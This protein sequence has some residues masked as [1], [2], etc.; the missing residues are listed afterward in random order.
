MSC[1]S[2]H[3]IFQ[4]SRLWYSLPL[5]QSLTYTFQL[6]NNNL[7]IIPLFQS[8]DYHNRNHGI[9]PLDENRYTASMNRVLHIC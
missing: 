4:P 9:A 3:L 8:T 5:F 6:L 2:I 7:M 1:H